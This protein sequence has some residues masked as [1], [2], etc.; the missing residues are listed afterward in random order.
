M[1][2]EYIPTTEETR[3]K[4]HRNL[5]IVS[6]VLVIIVMGIYYFLNNEGPDETKKQKAE[7]A[8]FSSLIDQKNAESIWRE[9]AQ[10][11]LKEQERQT[12]E[13]KNEV[14]QLKN[15]ETNKAIENDPRFLAMQ[16]EIQALKETIKIKTHS[17][18][19]TIQDNNY[20]GQVFSTVPGAR[21]KMRGENIISEREIGIDND[22]LNLRSNNNLP[23]KNPDTF[24]PAATHAEA[25]MIGAADLSAGVQS[26]SNPSPLVFRITSNGT[27]PNGYKSHLKDCKL[28]AAAI[29]DISS[30]RGLARLERLSCVFPSGEIVEQQVEGTIYAKDGK[31]GIRGT[32]VW[33][34]GA[35]LGR[36]AVAGTLSGLGSAISQ[37]YSTTS[38]SPLGSTQTVNNNEIFKYGVAQGASNAMEKLADYNI[39]RAEQYHPI[40]QI[41]AAQ[42]VDVVFLKGFYL[43]GKPRDEN[44]NVDKS[45]PSRLF[46]ASSKQTSTGLTLSE[47]ELE[48]I[49]QNERNMGW[50]NKDRSG[51]MQ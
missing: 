26:Q 19:Q 48:K 33:R 30:E 11:K 4:Q 31:N 46:P 32:P 9:R 8:S 20:Q 12:T 28:I 24:V 40:V 41:S 37:T 42:E 5:L 27:L 18:V 14:A 21:V 47:N 7:A 17:Q 38:I 35:L 49:K 29:G 23:K 51:D 10:N 1:I 39:R 44:N 34:E 45:E 16:N 13:L 25:I 2:D 6:G 43:D 3:T 15:G 50:V 22:E 36:A